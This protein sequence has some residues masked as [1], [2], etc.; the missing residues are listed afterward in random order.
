MRRLRDRGGVSFPE[1][2]L[3]CLEVI[4]SFWRGRYGLGR[5]CCGGG[6]RNSHRRDCRYPFTPAD[7]PTTIGAN[8]LDKI[9][10]I[11]ASS[12]LTVTMSS[13][14]TM[15]SAFSAATANVT[16]GATS[17]VMEDSATKS[18]LATFVGALQSRR[19]SL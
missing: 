4:F 14:S 15:V 13:L 17:L 3:S 6:S 8:Y 2:Y 18:V 1:G 7:V 16:P 12:R 19:L 9:L 11:I 10:A 5:H